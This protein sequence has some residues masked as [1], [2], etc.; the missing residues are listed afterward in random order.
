MRRIGLI[1]TLSCVL[2]AA[3]P[4]RVSE[5]RKVMGTRATVVAI[6][7]QEPDARR[8]VE[9]VFTELTRVERL[10][11]RRDPASEISRVNRDAAKRPV[12][13]S[14]ETFTL[15]QAAVRAAQQ[16]GGTFDITVGP[17]IALWKRAGKL[18][19]LPTTDELT[20]VRKRVG[21]QKLK[22]D[23]EARSV[24]FAVEG[25]RIDLG[26]I[27]KGYGIDRGLAVLK[28]FKL[29]AGLVDVG[30]DMAVFGA[31]PGQAG[32]RVGVQNPFGSGLVTRLVVRDGAVATS[33]NYFRFT[34]IR[35][36]RYSHILDPRTGRPAD[37]APSVTVVAPTAM[38]ADWLATALSVEGLSGVA[39]LIKPR[40]GVEA[41]LILGTAQSA[42][43]V[44]SSGFAAHEMPPSATQSSRP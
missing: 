7:P 14:L 27:A 36:K 15:L 25:M 2:A 44:R 39:R 28:R 32:W 23:P 9:A 29:I 35:G 40:P 5:T 30:G 17:L 1:S 42:S 6:G 24:R 19:R 41:M 21:W 3:P 31:P 33:G 34:T 43:P 8:A 22:L 10:F 4:A 13:V 26:G 16:S 38:E 18:N 11:S 20:A 12:V 37:A